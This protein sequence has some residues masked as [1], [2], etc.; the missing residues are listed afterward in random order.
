MTMDEIE[1]DMRYSQ[2]YY[3]DKSMIVLGFYGG[4]D[5]L[6]FYARTIIAVSIPISFHITFD[7][8]VMLTPYFHI[9]NNLK[10]PVQL[11]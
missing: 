6:D 4:R 2:Y 9:L 3:F 8:K 7:A 10:A 5:P 1:K 11:I